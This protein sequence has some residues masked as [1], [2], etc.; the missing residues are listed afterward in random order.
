MRKTEII[1]GVIALLALVLKFLLIP[2]SG[3]L[4][5]VSLLTLSCI[6]CFL[7]FALFNDIRLRQIFKKDSYQGITPK[8][9]I[10][11]IGLGFALSEIVI[12]ILF[13]FQSWN[14]STTYLIIGLIFT[15]IILIVALGAYSK[16]KASNFYKGIFARIF[17]VGG[18]GLLTLLTPS[19]LLRQV[20]HRDNPE[21]LEQINSE[22]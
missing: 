8:K 10:G 16:N 20:L 12:G 21:I 22:Q 18:V 3:L 4:T 17:I 7:A 2:G 9:M 15:L 14:G 11:V 13:K 6:Y 5:V 19:D 1:I